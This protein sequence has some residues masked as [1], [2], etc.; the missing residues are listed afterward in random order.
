METITEKSKQLFYKKL[1][2]FPK[3]PYNLLPHLPLV[4]K[5]ANYLLKKYPEADE[6]VVM[7]AVW[8]HDIGHYPIKEIDHAITGEAIA[9]D[10]LEK[11]KLEQEKIN[12]ILHCIRAH[13]CKDVMPETIEAKII[14]C[15]DSA[16]HISDITIYAD[17][18]KNGKIEQAKAKLERD[19]RD[20]SM[21]PEV[22]KQLKPLYKSWKKL[23]GNYEKL[24]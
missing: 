6:E 9:K 1:K 24:N 14:A 16:S 15:A 23:L 19:F 22:K 5:W 18:V 7:T 12:K 13:R 20:V 4:E 11:N 3:D 2:D 21:F 17:M 10:F 8:L